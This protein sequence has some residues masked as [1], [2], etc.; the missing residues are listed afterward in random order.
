[1]Q[2]NKLSIALAS[3]LSLITDAA[4]AADVS[5]HGFGTAGAAMGNSSTPYLGHIDDKVSFENDTRIGLQVSHWP[6]GKRPCRG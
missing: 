5:I 1:M 4:W 3:A 2:T 6:A